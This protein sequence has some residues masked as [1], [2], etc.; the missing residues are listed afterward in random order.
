MG[1]LQFVRENGLTSTVEEIMNRFKLWDLDSADFLSL[2]TGS[3]FSDNNEYLSVVEIA[4]HKE[5]IFHKFRAN[6]Q[7]RK[8]LE[9]VTKSLASEYLDLIPESER[10]LLSRLRACDSV[11]GPLRYKFGSYGRYSPTTIRYLYFHTQYKEYF[12]DLGNSKVIEI[13]GGFGGQAAV[14]LTLN[15]NLSWTIF[16]LPEVLRLQEKYLHA[17]NPDVKVTFQTGLEITK[18]HGD[19]LISNYALSEISRDLQLKYFELVISNCTKGYMAWNTISEVE[20]GGLALSEVLELIP[21]S[22]YVDEVPLSS[23]GNVI[24]YWGNDELT[25]QLI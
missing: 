5:K 7:Y 12:G 10:A 20:N 11:G 4:A 1:L 13:G 24:V 2:G 18:T 3:S 6:R 9:H 17:T 22:N 8:I 14:S 23:P 16:D 19:F 15:P 21:G 25:A